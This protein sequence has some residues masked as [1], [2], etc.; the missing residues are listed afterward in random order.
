MND[1]SSIPHDHLFRLGLS[2]R[3]GAGPLLS[4]PAPSSEKRLPKNMSQ[5][6]AKTSQ[7]SAG[8]YSSRKGWKLRFWP[9][10]RRKHGHPDQ[11][12]GTGTVQEATDK[13]RQKVPVDTS[14]NETEQTKEQ[15]PVILMCDTPPVSLEVAGNSESLVAT[16]VAPD[17]FEQL[18]EPQPATQESEALPIGP[19]VTGN[20]EAEVA[21]DVAPDE[22]GH[23][24]EPDPAIPKAEASADPEVDQ[25]K[26][27]LSR[28]RQKVG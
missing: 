12:S 15:Q 1:L 11:N 9:F 20:S 13:N 7:S 24:K 21:N 28:R 16:D 22:S 2:F 14:P 3:A 26:P 8:P 25:D 4:P 10:R 5:V 27:P 17:E 18:K 19:E 6:G 23:P